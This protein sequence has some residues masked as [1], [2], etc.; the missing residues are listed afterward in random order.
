[1][2]GMTQMELM[3]RINELETKQTKIQIAMQQGNSQLAEEILGEYLVLVNRQVASLENQ[4]PEWKR[5]LRKAV[6][7]S[8]TE[9]V[10][11]DS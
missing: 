1:M 9:G 3:A 8:E 5:K 2:L 6:K 4:L 10:G 7:P 11:A